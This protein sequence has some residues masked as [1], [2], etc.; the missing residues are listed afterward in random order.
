[1]SNK[2]LSKKYQESLKQRREKQTKRERALEGT[3]IAPLTDK[4]NRKDKNK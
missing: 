4:N 2:E 3:V 1:M